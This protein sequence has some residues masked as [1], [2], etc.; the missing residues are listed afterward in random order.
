MLT[1]IIC[2]DLSCHLFTSSER[3]LDSQL[4]G[5]L[6][7]RRSVLNGHLR[8]LS[9]LVE[10][11][12]A[13]FWYKFVFQTTNSLDMVNIPRFEKHINQNSVHCQFQHEVCLNNTP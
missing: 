11:I 8:S 2:K 6:G 3:A 5:Y 10:M 7:S 1:G 9:H 12:I 4:N 13:L